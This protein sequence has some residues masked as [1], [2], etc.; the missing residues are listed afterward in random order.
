MEQ[1][2]IY[3]Q[4]FFLL[5]TLGLSAQENI[6]A[7]V[8][9]GCATLQVAFSLDNAQPLESYSAVEWRFGDGA[10]AVGTLSPTH[11]YDQP[12]LYDVR[13]VL[14][15]TTKL[16]EEGFIEVGERPYADF[17][18]SDLSADDSEYRYR[19]E[20]AYFSPATGDSLAYT[21]RFPDGTEVYD[22]TA[23]YTYAEEGIYPVF[24]ML[25][26][27]FGCTDS[28]T[29]KVPVSKQLLVPNVFSPNNDEVNDHFEVT[30]P[31]DYQYTFRVFTRDG[32]LIYSSESPL[33]RWDGRITGG[34]E[35]PEGVYYYTIRSSDTPVET[36]LSGFLH[37]FR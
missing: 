9:S 4:L 27:V 7:D 31:G 35:A 37:L 21:W 33:I 2:T 12:G 22:S 14:N 15:E 36:S 30:T 34:R 17:T 19:F 28:I 8:R 10:T 13:C 23:E 1:R 20:T 6:T 32:L 29:K 16:E 3:I 26:G 25:E 11:N 5:I 18:F 24:L